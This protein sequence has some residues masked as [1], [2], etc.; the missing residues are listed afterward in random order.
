MRAT[1]RPANE[2]DIGVLAEHFREMWL[3]IG[4]RPETLREDWLDLVAAFV[5]RARA[6]SEFAAFVAEADGAVAG[7]A[8]C[9]LASGPYPEIRRESSHRAGYI[10]GVYIRPE[11]RRQAVA[12]RL[13][14]AALDHLKALGCTRATLHASTAGDPV[15]RS[16]GFTGTNE[17]SLTLVESDSEG[18]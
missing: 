9:Q 8:A 4:W 14:Q 2:S 18:G 15:Y 1:I 13:T 17:L 3:E 11:Y 6:E 12:T 5:E 16:M 10:W 7:T